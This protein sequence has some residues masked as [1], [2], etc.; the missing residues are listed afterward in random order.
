MSGH[1]KWSQI[2]HK[3]AVTDAKKGAAFS[4]IAREITIAARAAGGDPDMNPH[5]RAAL[6]RARAVGLTKETIER[7]IQRA[8]GANEGTDLSEFVYE[9]TLPHGVTLIIEGITD[10]TN[11]SFAEIRH[12][13]TTRGAKIA[14]PGSVLWNYQKIGILI[15]TQEDNSGKTPDD[16]E[17]AII[18]AGADDFIFDEMGWFTQTPFAHAETV[19]VALEQAGVRVQESS[20]EYRATTTVIPAEMERMTTEQII[21]A[22]EEHDDVQEVFSNL[23]KE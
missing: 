18:D 20:H 10:N 4:K 23:Q 17:L 7:A 3:K 12:L 1:S 5:L 11:R 6:E 21:N 9:A 2:K 15:I 14:D 13:L 22:L 16:I 8:H 19:R